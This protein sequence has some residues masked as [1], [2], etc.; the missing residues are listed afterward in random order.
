MLYDNAQLARAYLHAWQLT[1]ELAYRDVAV[2]VLDFMARELLRPDGTFAASLDAD[3]DG[4]EGATFTWTPRRSGPSWPRPAATSST[5]SST[6]YGVTTAG[7]WEGSTIL[8]RVRDDQELAA[9]FGL[10]PAEV[11]A[12]AG[13]GPGGPARRRAE[14]PQ[15]ARDDK[16]LAAW[17]GLAIG[18]FADAAAA[19]SSADDAATRALG[20]TYRAVA[21]RA[22][23]ALLAG[24][25]AWTAGCGGP[26]RTAGPVPMACSRI[27]R[28]S[29]TACSPSTRRRSTSAGSRAHRPWRRSCWT[30]FADPDGG[31]FDTA[32][33]AEALM[34]RPKDL[35]DNALPS[36]GAMAATVLLR[37]AALTG[38]DRYREAAERALAGI[39]AGRATP[40][41]VL[42]PVARRHRLRDAPIVEV[43]IVGDAGDPATAALV[44]VAR[45][46]FRP[47]AC[48]AVGGGPGGQRR[49]RSWRAASRSTAVPPPTSVAGSSAG[50][51]ST[52]PEAL[53]A[54][55]PRSARRRA[56][57]SG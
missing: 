18:A 31:F 14:R 12:A 47:I 19:I 55:L 24:C 41:D 7:N 15:P 9:R 10:Q 40:P 2:G 20:A 1:G 46:G 36:G 45:R 38:E 30:S 16:A 4:V 13:R 49:A 52:E 27:T 57:S 26:G 50:C 43:A 23:E 53:E 56:W 35:Q 5:C 51:R 34:T 33:D 21:E 44:E 39:V 22:A 17:N 11:S 3:T 37:L 28:I 42:R 29:P 48:L 32:D 8:C 6:A 25:A 54:L